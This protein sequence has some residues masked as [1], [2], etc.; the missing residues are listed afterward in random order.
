VA[1][2]GLAV[3]QGE[4]L[5]AAPGGYVLARLAQHRILERRA[6]RDQQR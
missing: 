3:E 1:V 6:T 4:R 2:V 5:L